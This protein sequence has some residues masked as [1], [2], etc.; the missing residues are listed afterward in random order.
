VT[1]CLAGYGFTT[2]AING[3]V[4]MTTSGLDSLTT[5]SPVTSN[6]AAGLALSTSHRSDMQIATNNLYD[7]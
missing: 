5:Q 6:V 1:D 4:T 7:Y 3:V 2:S